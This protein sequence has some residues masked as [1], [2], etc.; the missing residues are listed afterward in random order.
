[1]Q[2]QSSSKKDKLKV[3]VKTVT[4]IEHMFDFKAEMNWTIKYVNI[5]V[6]ILKVHKR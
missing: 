3:V 1:M 5:K 4:H 6:H 2:K